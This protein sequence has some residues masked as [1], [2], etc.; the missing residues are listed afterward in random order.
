MALMP[1][2]PPA[3]VITSGTN[4]ANKGRWIDSNLIRFDDGSLKNIGGWELLK[5]APLTGAIISLY[6][7]SKNDG[8]QILAIGTREKVY[9]YYNYVWRDITPT[10][11]VSPS[12][13]DPKG[14]GAF[15]YGSEDYGDA[16]SQSG[17]S[18]NETS[19]SFDNWGE[20]LVFTN[21]SDG[22]LFQWRPDAG[23][24]SP[25][26]IATVITNAPTSCNALVVT[27]ERHL[28][29]IGSNNDPRK[30]SWSSRES[31]TTW[32]ASS[33]NT[34]GDLQIPT[35]G[36][37]LSAIKHQTDILIFTD[38]GL[39]KLYYAGSPFIYGISDAG[40]NCKAMSQK[41]VVSAGN[42]IAW[43]GEKSIFTY[44]GAVREV[45][46]A[47]SD[48]I[49]DNIN[50]TYRKKTTGGHNSQ[51]NEI[52]WFFPSGTSQVPNKYIIWNYVTNVYA[53]GEMSRSSYIDQGVFE[54]PIAGD[55]D[56]YIYFHE[57]GNLFNSYNLGTAKPTATSGAIQIGQGDQYI[58][59]TQVIPDSEA[60]SLPGVTLSF[61]GRF[62]PLGAQTDFGS[63]TFNSDGYSDIRVSAREIELKITGD[64]NQ[65]FTLGNIR[66]D[67]KNGGRR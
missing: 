4:Y 25:D 27:N 57:K 28:V 41:S 33:T 19:Y 13:T 11:F 55:E 47:V 18:F 38:T 1:I 44:D 42:F 48:Y 17:L 5:S 10:S 39:G 9:T 30:I 14:F 29:A 22:R 12:S 21:K 43:L 67:L 49:F 40:T 58:H 56:G 26:T 24:G 60:N 53:V 63:V 2:T 37:A 45:P 35:G 50:A 16:R 23:S 34:A 65:N 7:Y 52:W 3:G 36:R 64:T 54:Y 8:D 66:L 6:A 51:F 46:C 59:A 32:T 15:T 62:T 61:K 31:L 20:Y